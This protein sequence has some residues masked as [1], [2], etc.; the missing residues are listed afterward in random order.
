M[1]W[2]RLAAITP[3]LVAALFGGL[4]GS[5]FTWWINRPSATTV[6][7]NVTTT[8]LGNDPAVRSAVPN[9]RLNIGTEEVPA[10]FIHT[11]ELSVP[12][13]PYLRHGEVVVTFP[14]TN[15][16][17]GTVGTRTFGFAAP[18]PSAVH[19]LTCAAHLNGVR[20]T[21]G[22]LSPKHPATFKLTFATDHGVE[23]KI[24]SAD[25][26]VELIPLQE[27]TRGAKFWTVWT[28]VDVLATL[29]TIVMTFL[30]FVTVR[31]TVR[32]LK[33]KDDEIKAAMDKLKAAG[34]TLKGGR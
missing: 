7:Y 31:S 1:P 14:P 9:L 25:K 23:P 30:T 24:E 5:V 2:P 33:E 21:M 32:F 27:Y 22:P 12:A 10:L 20:C 34:D 26:E 19:E 4:A 16:G 8:A 17:G 6:I 13:G 11:L 29:I 18:S 28:A 3:L 15:I